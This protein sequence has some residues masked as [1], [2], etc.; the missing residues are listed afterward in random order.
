M[1]IEERRTIS[2]TDEN[3]EEI[4]LAVIS[5]TKIAGTN[6]LIVEDGEE[7]TDEGFTEVMLLKESE[8]GTDEEAIYEMVEDEEEI[9]AVMKVFA[10]ILDD[11]EFEL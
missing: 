5:Q 8:E 2:F 9:S 1:N 11:V 7:T 4:E 6:Y 10:E 3:G